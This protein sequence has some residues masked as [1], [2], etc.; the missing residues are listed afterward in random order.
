MNLGW[1]LIDGD[2]RNLLVADRDARIRVE[3][4]IPIHDGDVT[5]GTGVCIHTVRRPFAAVVPR[6]GLRL[7]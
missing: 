6:L 5:V 1:C 3:R 4:Q 7:K 2:A